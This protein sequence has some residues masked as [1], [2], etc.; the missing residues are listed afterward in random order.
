MTRK[1]FFVQRIDADAESVDLSPRASHH[2]EHVLRL[3]AGDRIELR[4]GEGEAWSGEIAAI[5]K[6]L[7]SVR[8]TGRQDCSIL[9]SPLHLTL[10]LGLARSDI[11]DMVVRQA[12]ELG[13]SRLAVFRAARSQ[14]GLAGSRAEKTKERW[15][16]I[17]REAICQCGR[18]KV[19]Q[20]DIFEDTDS[21]VGSFGPRAEEN[22]LKIFA[23]E[24]DALESLEGLIRAKP[25]C[26]EIVA[27]IG[28]EGGWDDPEI[29]FLMD[30]GFIP[31]RLGPRILRFETAAIAL[32]ST[33]QLLWGDMGETKGKGVDNEVH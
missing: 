17:A 2:A 3:R 20:I 32:V 33:V 10:A 12:T 24:H 6:G 9:E 15:S 27:A 13:V 26:F 1:C 8:L 19:P 11:M 5:K 29:S 23:R 4:D 22:I 25:R 14:Y 16:K 31:V 21:F 7:V 18:T 28:P 30:S